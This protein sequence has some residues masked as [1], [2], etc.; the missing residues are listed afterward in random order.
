MKP[1]S[2]LVAGTLLGGAVYPLTHDIYHSLAIAVGSV[3]IDL[4]HIY[5][6]VHEWGWGEG[7]RKLVLAGLGRSRASHQR[8]YL[9]LH[10]WEILL[11]A[12]LLGPFLFQSSYWAS[13]LLGTTIH[14]FMDQ[15]GNG[16]NGL[17]YF[18]AYRIHKRFSTSALKV[19][20]G[21]RKTPIDARAGMG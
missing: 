6:F 2:H 20:P 5:D 11:L 4:D 13:F 18:L 19:A 12:A 21:K 8:A 16:F 15:V 3:V 9:I 1:A 14:L 7:I 17:S 10:S